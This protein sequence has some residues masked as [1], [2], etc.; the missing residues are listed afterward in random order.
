MT[1]PHIFFG[2]AILAVAVYGIDKFSSNTACYEIVQVERYLNGSVL[3][4]KCKGRTWTLV[5]HEG[6]PAEILGYVAEEPEDKVKTLV[7]TR[8]HRGEGMLSFDKSDK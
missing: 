7:W 4:D 6:T 8:V 3:L 2:L 5:Q 1:K